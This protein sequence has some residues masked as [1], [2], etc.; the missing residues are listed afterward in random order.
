MKSYDR[1]RVFKPAPLWDATEYGAAPSPLSK[2]SRRQADGCDRSRMVFTFLCGVILLAV[3]TLR[4][5]SIAQLSG[6][7]SPHAIEKVLASQVR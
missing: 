6:Q 5:K 7:G 4:G 1:S 3:A 2:A